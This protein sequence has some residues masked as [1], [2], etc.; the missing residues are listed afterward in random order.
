VGTRALT[1]ADEPKLERFALMA[2]FPPDRPPPPGVQAMPHVRRWLDDWS[3]AEPG[4]CWHEQNELLGAAWARKVEPVLARSA[5]GV[6]L[7]E[8]VI[9]VD[10]DRRGQGVGRAL[11]E[12]LIARARAAGEPG[13]CLSVSERNS[14]AVQL[15]ESVG[16]AI[17]GRGPSGLLTMALHLDE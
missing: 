12:A 16:F 8:V 4:V 1:A 15:Y 9:A 2:A 6:P 10:P 17:S 3:E 7:A 11:M 13:L 5:A 14:P